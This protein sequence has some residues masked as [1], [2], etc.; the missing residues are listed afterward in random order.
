MIA[1]PRSRFTVRQMMITM[2]VIATAI[3][4]EQTRR[5]LMFYRGM[6]EFHAIR[7]RSDRRLIPIAES[8]KWS[9]TEISDSERTAR[10]RLPQANP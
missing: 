9:A 2:A 7:E 1:L 10:I 6:V 8:L 3:A 4:A 5:R